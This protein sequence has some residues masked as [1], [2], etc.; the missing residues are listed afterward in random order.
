M[1]EKVLEK[2]ER[3]QDSSE[4]RDGHFVTRCDQGC[5]Q[6]TQKT[7]DYSGDQ[8]TQ[9]ELREDRMGSDDCRPHSNSDG[10]PS[11]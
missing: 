1:T 3:N 6:A 4:C 5:D 10:N 11:N 9:S 8:A 2:N 7:R